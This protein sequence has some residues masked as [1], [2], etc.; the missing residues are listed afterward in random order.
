MLIGIL[1]VISGLLFAVTV[2]P[3]LTM[4]SAPPENAPILRHVVDWGTKAFC[5]FASCGM[6]ILGVLL[7]IPLSID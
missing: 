3:F 7:L 5:A 6:L 4:L 2:A 1:L